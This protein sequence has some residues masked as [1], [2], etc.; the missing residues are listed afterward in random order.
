[1]FGS[2]KNPNQQQMP[3]ATTIS[4]GIICNNLAGPSSVLPECAGRLLRPDGVLRPAERGAVV[5]LGVGGVTQHAVVV[6]QRE[7]ALGHL[8]PLGATPERNKCFS[9]TN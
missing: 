4:K 7:G 1:M 2:H 3:N 9:F 5:G 8:R 6:L